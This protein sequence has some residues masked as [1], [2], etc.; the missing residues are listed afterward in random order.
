MHKPIIRKFD[1]RKVQSPFIDN[2]WDA[3]PADMQSIS[4]FDKASRFFYVLLTFIANMHGLYP[5]KIRKDSTI[6][7]AFQIF[8]D[9]SKRKPNEIWVDKGSEFYNRSMK[10]WLEKW[11]RNVFNASVIGERF[12]RTL[13]NKIYKY[14]TTISKMFILIN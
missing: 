4:K 9:E 5:W 1:K 12:I 13:K 14:I 6:T 2:I 11:Y 3:D 10:S 8:F 7:N